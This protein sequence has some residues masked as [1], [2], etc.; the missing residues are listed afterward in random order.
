MPVF[1]LVVSIY[2]KIGDNNTLSDTPTP[3]TIISL[4]SL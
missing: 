2:G 1:W 3:V 4:P